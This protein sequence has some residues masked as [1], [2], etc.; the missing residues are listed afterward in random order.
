MRSP[1]LNAP[2]APPPLPLPSDHNTGTLTC[3]SPYLGVAVFLHEVLAVVDLLFILAQ[4]F[5]AFQ[6]RRK[7]LLY[8]VVPNARDPAGVAPDD[9]VEN[10]VFSDI[11][12]WIT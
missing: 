7:F 2:S 11:K 8:R 6:M 4:V 5:R 3:Q 9:H 1:D 10:A 12:A